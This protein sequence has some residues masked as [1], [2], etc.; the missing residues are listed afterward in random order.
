[1]F[2]CL[3]VF[4]ERPPSAGTMKTYEEIISF[5]V[6]CIAVHWCNPSIC[7]LGGEMTITK[8]QTSMLRSSI[9]QL[10]SFIGSTVTCQHG[11]WREHN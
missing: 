8:I 7:S 4:K 10:T 9:G 5:R 2:K 3:N 1:M 6:S 11:I